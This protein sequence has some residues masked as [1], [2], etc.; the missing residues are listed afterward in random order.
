[1]IE[2]WR[3]NEFERST[4]T[5]VPASFLTA[6]RVVRFCIHCSFTNDEEKIRLKSTSCRTALTLCM[7]TLYTRYYRFTQIHAMTW[8]P[9]RL[10]FVFALGWVGVPH[11]PARLRLTLLGLGFGQVGISTGAQASSRPLMR[12]ALGHRRLRT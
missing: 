3:Y 6:V 9:V 2:S 11:F 12:R 8:P 10:S 1:M 4:Q 7:T 5:A